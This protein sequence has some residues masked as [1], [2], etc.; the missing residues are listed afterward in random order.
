MKASTML[1]L[2]FLRSASL[3]RNPCHNIDSA[4]LQTALFLQTTDIGR[5]GV[6]LPTSPLTTTALTPSV[7]PKTVLWRKCFAP[8]RGRE[9]NRHTQLTDDIIHLTEAL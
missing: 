1:M 9:Q 4:R 3:P 6:I 8:S 5:V 7:G 2:M